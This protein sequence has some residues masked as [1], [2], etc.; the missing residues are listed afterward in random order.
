VSL[1]QVFGEIEK[2]LRQKIKLVFEEWRPGD[3]R[4]FVADTRRARDVLGL[5]A[6][7]GWREGLADLASWLLQA[8]KLSRSSRQ[9]A[10]VELA[11]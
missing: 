3:Q 11:S 1:L 6:P 4:Y 7:L 2:R 5:A 9:P 10:S 8:E